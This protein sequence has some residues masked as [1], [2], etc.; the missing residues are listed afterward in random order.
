[1]FLWFDKGIS[2]TIPKRYITHKE[3]FN[4]KTQLDFSFILK[5]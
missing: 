4:P 3:Q 2:K 1:M 5:L